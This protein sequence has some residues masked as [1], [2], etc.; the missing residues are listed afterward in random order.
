MTRIGSLFA[1]AGGLDMAVEKVFGAR[2]VWQSEIDP[3]A[4][5]VLAKRFPHAN[6]LGDIAAIKWHDVEPVEILCGGFPCT[7]VSVAGKRS[8]MHGTRS[9][10][11]SHMAEAIDILRPQIVII[12]NVRGLLNADAN[13]PMEPDTHDLGNPGYRPVL[14]AAGAVCGDLADIGAYD[15]R[16]TTLAASEIGAP[17]QRKRVFIIAKLNDGQSPPATQ[18]RKHRTAG[19]VGSLLPTPTTQDGTNCGGPAQFQRNT[20]PLNAVVTLLPTPPSR[21]AKGGDCSPNGG[22]SLPEAATNKNINW[23]QFA[24]AIANWE[25]ITRAAP[26][27]TE[28]NKNGQPRLSPKFS[29]WLMG[30]PAGHVTD[31]VIGISRTDQLRIIGNG[32]VPQQAEHAITYLLNTHSMAGGR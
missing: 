8:G 22:P 24:T 20:P 15:V 21:D 18:V 28:T 6:Q 23:G 11:W 9:G 5:K 4:T 2:T 13:R 26:F 17:H 10:M 16:W 30:W 27:P 19:H 31:P 7:D 3:A 29:E 12:E 25:E 1:G 32:V 14:R